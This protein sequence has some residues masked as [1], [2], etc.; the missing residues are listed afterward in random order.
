MPARMTTTRR[1][2]TG[3]VSGEACPQTPASK[4]AT[5]KVFS[6]RQDHWIVSPRLAMDLGIRAESHYPRQS[7]RQSAGRSA[8]SLSGLGPAATS[9]GFPGCPAIRVPPRIPI[10]RYRCHPE[11]RGDSRYQ[12]NSQ[13]PC[14]RFPILRGFQSQSEVHSPA[15]G[16]QLQPNQLLQPEGFSQ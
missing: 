7:I 8:E 6:N 14:C 4:R 5:D 12:P 1:W 2:R 9:M 11:L 10:Q 16:E 13:F 15:V 3:S